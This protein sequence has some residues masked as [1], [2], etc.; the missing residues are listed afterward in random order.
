MRK[1]IERQDY[2][3]INCDNI[4]CDYSL[5]VKGD[6]EFFINMPCP[7]CGENLLSIDDYLNHVRL[8]KVVKFINKW[9]SWITL[10]TSNKRQAYQVDVK[11]GVKF[12]KV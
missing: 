3:T 8:I 11:D 12:K 1:L 5:K 6:I 9:F 2:T 7:K 10:F 4:N